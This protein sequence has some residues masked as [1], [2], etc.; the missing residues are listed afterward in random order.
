MAMATYIHLL[1]CGSHKLRSVVEIYGKYSQVIQ[2]YLGDP[3][4]LR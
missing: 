2:V 1:F 4:V 3:G